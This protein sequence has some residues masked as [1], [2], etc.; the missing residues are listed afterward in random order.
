MF[1]LKSIIEYYIKLSTP[2][3]LCFIDASKA[4]DRVEHCTLF[5][6]LLKRQLPKVIVRFIYQWYST[7]HFII[8]WGETLSVPFTVTNGVRQGGVLSP[9]LFNVYIDD[10]SESLSKTNVGCNMNGVTMNHLVYADDTVL[11]ATSPAALQKLLNS[12]EEYADSHDIIYNVTKTY[13]MC[14]KPKCFKNLTVPDVFL[15]GRILKYIPVQKY[16]GCAISNNFNDD[17]D[18]ERHIRYVYSTG[19]SL[20]RNFKL[21]SDEV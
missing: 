16:L 17:L 9:A 15:N 7:Q 11:L 4:F 6:K 20:V 2:L 21:C 1:V 5:Q 13:C 19:N 8:K 10:L 14:I 12:C 3:Y 18:I